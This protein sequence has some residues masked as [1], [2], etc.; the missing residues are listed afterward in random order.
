MKPLNDPKRK[1]EI[2]ELA[3]A[4]LDR[5][6]PRRYRVSVDPDGIYDDDGWT[7]IVVVS[8]NDQRDRDFYDSLE[9]AE[10]EILTEDGPQYLL[11]PTIPS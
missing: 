4:A 7:Y 11:V 3:Q 1:L 6:Q 5:H 10:E 9:E 8:E 2:I